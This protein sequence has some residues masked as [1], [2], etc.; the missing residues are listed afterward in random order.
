[1]ASPQRSDPPTGRLLPGTCWLW[2]SI[3]SLIPLTSAEPAL[4][5]S[6][7]LVIDLGGRDPAKAAVWCQDDRRLVQVLTTDPAVATAARTAW[8]A[9]H[10]DGRATIQVV[11]DLKRLPYATALVDAVVVEQW[12]AIDPAEV[13]RV[14]A[15]RGRVIVRDG[16]ERP[17][18]ALKAKRE[19]DGSWRLPADPGAGRTDHAPGISAGGLQ[20]VADDL[21]VKRNHVT[22]RCGG[23][24][25]PRTSLEPKRPSGWLQWLDGPHRNMREV[26]G[27]SSILAAY[28]V[29]VVAG[30]QSPLLFARGGTFL[31]DPMTPG[32]LEVRDAFNGLTRWSRPFF[33]QPYAGN[34]LALT[35]R[36]LLGAVPAGPGV[37]RIAK[38]PKRGD[39]PAAQDLVAWDLADGR[40]IG[41]S[42]VPGN[43]LAMGILVEGEQI[44]V[45]R[46]DGATGYKAN[47]TTPWVQTWSVPAKNL[48]TGSLER[49]TLVLAEGAG[50][51][52]RFLD[53][54]MGVRMV[55]FAS[56]TAWHANDGSMAWTVLAESL[57]APPAEASATTASATAPAKAPPARRFL[58]Y[59]QG[60]GLGL[61]HAG[62]D[63]VAIDTV[64][65][66]IR[67]RLPFLPGRSAALVGVVDGQVAVL[68]DAAIRLVEPASGA[69]RARLDR[70]LGQGYGPWACV[71]GGTFSAGLVRNA[72]GS[73]SAAAPAEP[74]GVG[75]MTIDSTCRIGAV[76]GEGQ[77]YCPMMSCICYSGRTRG[78]YAVRR[79]D[80][81]LNM[82]HGDL[83][84]GPAFGLVPGAVPSGGQ[85][86]GDAARSCAG[87]AVSGPP[88]LKWRTRLPIPDQASALAQVS[89]RAEHRH[90][91]AL[92]SPVVSD[93]LVLA[94][95]P[96]RQ[97]I[98]A[99]RRQD[100]SEAWRFTADGLI[101]GPPTIAGPLIFFGCHDGRVYAL[102]TAT[103]RLAWRR[104]IS[105]VDQQI[106][107]YGRLESRFP[108]PAAVVVRDGAVLATAGLGS[109]QG[110]WYAELGG[111]D[112]AVQVYRRLPDVAPNPRVRV[113]DALAYPN[114]VLSA[115][116]AAPDGSATTARLWCGNQA[117]FP[118]A[119]AAGQLHTTDSTIISIARTSSPIGQANSSQYHKLNPEPE[120]AGWL[121]QSKTHE[122]MPWIAGPSPVLTT[123][124]GDPVGGHTPRVEL[125]ALGARGLHLAWTDRTIFSIHP[126]GLPRRDDLDYDLTAVPGGALV[127]L[128]RDALAR[129]AQ[130][131]RTFPD[132]RWPKSLKPEELVAPLWYRVIAK[133]PVWALAVAGDTLFAAGPVIEPVTAHGPTVPYWGDDPTPPTI[134][135]PRLSPGWLRWLG[136]DGS[137]RAVIDLPASPIQDGI[138][139]QG[140]LIWITLHDGSI[141]CFGP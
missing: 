135:D 53:M 107:A 128:P 85:F 126:Y 39:G 65:G 59:G 70:G 102:E 48:F 134:R 112:G 114:D 120:K 79:V 115:E 83:E 139:P 67:W 90:P 71:D 116:P 103:G 99:L 25:Q 125:A 96:A 15:P 9:A 138:L 18:Q 86:R 7:L 49:G 28:G 55:P 35:P 68:E 57:A 121:A 78:Q 82:A 46:A 16:G 43:G 123:Q 94:A 44:V 10:L 92:S 34:I 77:V 110:I 27:A 119:V 117:L 61:V 56:L 93:D 36:W 84:R 105:P 30:A 38:P 26:K 136:P 33:T 60:L 17:G 97:Q 80:P 130:L 4:Q 109:Q 141:A 50:A 91:L 13:A 20:I 95:L 22:A 127:A 19:A 23:L 1:M 73:A 106:V 140:G 69:I 8:D 32:S 104:R 87:D 37:P 113:N 75:S 66:R 132:P 108:V 14:V 45:V 42:A 21:A 89:W 131:P 111:A 129:T 76:V 41:R 88:K 137:E 3:L 5:P 31:L 133:E 100:G 101:D 62:A 74:A 118:K 124:F 6:E 81:G 64:D 51:R 29:E 122:A 98:V 63:L 40:E 72:L 52:P 2:L 54:P 58:W 12:D 24:D 47:E 11:P